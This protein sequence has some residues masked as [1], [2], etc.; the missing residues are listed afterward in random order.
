VTLSQARFVRQATLPPKTEHQI[1]VVRIRSFNRHTS[2]RICG[3]VNRRRNMDPVD[4]RASILGPVGMPWLL[5][6]AKPSATFHDFDDYER[7]V[8]SAQ[9]T[10]PRAYQ[11]VLLGGEAGL[12]CGEM[13]ALEW[14]DVDL[15][16]RQLS[17][18][19]SEMEGPG[20]DAEGW[21]A[22]IRAV[23]DAVGD[24]APRSSPSQGTEGALVG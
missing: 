6:I 10:D 23:N 19:R 21:T 4:V 24:R 11:V 15:A 9:A 14:T 7:L 13:M 2:S 8:E 22:A 3:S 12:R 1:I 5:P 18:Q 17:V 20:D 16:K